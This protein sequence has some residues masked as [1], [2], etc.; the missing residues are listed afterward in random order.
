MFGSQGL[1]LTPLGTCDECS[2]A[3][4]CG[5]GFGAVQCL[6]S[7][8]GVVR[9]YCQAC[10]LSASTLPPLAAYETWGTDCAPTCAP[11]FQ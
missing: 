8:D 10:F 6:A 5:A 11:G 9:Y 7:G 4:V 1:Q 2:P 3:P